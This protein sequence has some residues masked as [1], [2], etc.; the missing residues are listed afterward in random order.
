MLLVQGGLATL[1]RHA[2]LLLAGGVFSGLLLQDL[3]A[4]LRPL[5]MPSI[6]VLLFLSV[7]RLDWRRV[8]AYA[9]RP[10]ATG[11]ASAW[12]LVVSPLL[13]WGLATGIGLPPALIAAMVLNAAASPVMS[14]TAF[15]RLLGF[16]V[17]LTVVVLAVTTLLL[18]VTLAPVALG[19]LSRETAIDP[20]DYTLRVGLF[21]VLPLAA[22]W[23]ARRI[24]G[25][26]RIDSLDEPLQGLT[27]IVLL[28]F[29]IAVMDG[30]TPRLAAEGG[31]VLL[32]L[33]CAFAINLGFQAVTALLFRPMGRRAALSLGLVSGNRNMALAFAVTGATE[34]DLLLY[35]A[36]AQIP[37][38]LSPLLT[39]Q[40]YGRLLAGRGEAGDA[41]N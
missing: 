4:T 6:G 1:G 33:A 22:A 5:L 29:A 35:L 39:R 18:P 23:V 3:A 15:A 24:A 25:E 28:V 12:Q 2:T 40:I 32:Y 36:V 9:R 30:V 16:D 31:T 13:V 27:V 11:L 34:P 7:L 37:I 20:A 38:Y 26:T 8:F 21:L 19:L 10:V 14:S 17:E 41:A